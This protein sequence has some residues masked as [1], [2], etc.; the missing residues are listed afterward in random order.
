MKKYLLYYMGEG[1]MPK[2][3]PMRAA[4]H[5]SLQVLELYEQGL[6]VQGNREFCVDIT[7]DQ[8]GWRIERFQG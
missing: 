1:S 5:G 2:T 4:K 8:T 7:A 3:V 6:L